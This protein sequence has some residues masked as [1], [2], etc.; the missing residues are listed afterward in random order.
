MIQQPQVIFLDAV[1]TL[2]TVEG[3]VGEVYSQLA[4]QYGV[5]SDSDTLNSAFFQA[6]A[7]ADPMAFPTAPAAKIPQLEYQWWETLAVETFKI[8]GIYQQF[9]DFP[10]FF[11]Q[12]YDHFAT[13]KPWFV[14]PDV[15]PT[16]KQWQ[17]Q[18]IELGVIS[19]FD[20][21]LYPVLDVLN[22]APFFKSV[23]ISTTVG[24]AK[25]AA[26]I[27]Q[28]A[29]QKH[30]CSLEEVL[31]IGDSVSADYQGAKQAGIQV[32]IVNREGD[33]TVRSRLNQPE[34]EFCTCLTEIHFN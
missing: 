22:L 15:L 5:N 16:L 14:Y 7:T 20:S 9:S 1:G 29:M 2:F 13:A 23:T 32:M 28:V 31:H 4:Q 11:A 30:N 3:S 12:L 18:G 34:L 21:R 25:P 27:F 8:A 17:N 24:A 10:Q 33:E 6:F 19:N 26:E